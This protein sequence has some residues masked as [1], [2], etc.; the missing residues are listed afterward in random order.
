MLEFVSLSDVKSKKIKSFSGGMVQRLGIAQA[1]LNDPQVLVL[2]EPTSGLDPKE[3]IR[4]R[5]LLERI[6]EDKIII[7]STHIVSDV[8]T[9]AGRVLLMNDGIIAEDT[10]VDKIGELC[11]KYFGEGSDLN[12]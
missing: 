11:I 12:D 5:K 9:I 3:R 10:A 6:A 8:A 2:D 4:F 1:L 7:Y